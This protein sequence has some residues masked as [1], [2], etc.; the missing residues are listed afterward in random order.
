MQDPQFAIT[1]GI[2][3]VIDTELP[4]FHGQR[5]TLLTLYALLQ[6]RKRELGDQWKPLTL[7]ASKKEESSWEVD[8][9][10]VTSRGSRVISIEFSGQLCDPYP[11]SRSSDPRMFYDIHSPMMVDVLNKL[12]RDNNG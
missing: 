5:T 12:L 3:F 1:E 4:L 7:T 11:L 8:L 10:R 9:V 6:Q 2:T